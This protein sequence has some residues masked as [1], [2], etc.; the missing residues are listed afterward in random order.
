MYPVLQIG[1]VALPLRPI[2]FLVAGWLCLGIT[3]RRLPRFGLQSDLAWSVGLL[4]G[5]VTLGSARLWYALSHWSAYQAN[6]GA[7]FAPT[8]GTLAVGEGALVGL[9]AGFIY[10]QRRRVPLK[11][12]AD[13]F[14]PGLLVAFGLASFGALLSG[15]AY[16]APT[17]VPWAITLWDERRHPSQIYEL[18]V[19]GAVLSVV[20]RWKNLPVGF[21]FLLAAMLYALGR[22]FV[23]AFRGDSLIISDGIRAMQLAWLSVALSAILLMY[24]QPLHGRESER[25]AT[26]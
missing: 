8:L 15:D 22:V 6:L 23:E 17:T 21:T 26:N 1:G 3:E 20:W 24:R 10:L 18:L 11:K 4:V 13:A 25:R 7:L 5:G 2:M 14:T 16:G 12:F 9:L 19:A